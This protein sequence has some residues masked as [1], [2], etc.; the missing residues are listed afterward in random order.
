MLSE[1]IAVPSSVFAHLLV[2]KASK[3]MF[4]CAIVR[5]ISE[6]VIQIRSLLPNHS[7]VNDQQTDLLNVPNRGS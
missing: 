2:S 5:T 3:M 7:K 1:G 6:P 4:I